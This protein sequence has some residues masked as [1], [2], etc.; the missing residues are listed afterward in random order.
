MRANSN[1]KWNYAKISSEGMITITYILD[2]WYLQLSQ[3]SVILKKGISP[4]IFCEHVQNDKSK[5]LYLYAGLIGKQILLGLVEKS[6][7]F[8]QKYLEVK[9]NAWSFAFC[10]R[11]RQNKVNIWYIHFEYVNSLSY[12]NVSFHLNKLLFKICIRKLT[13]C[14]VSSG[15]TQALWL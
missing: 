15:V 1:E 3:C 7:N 13:V 8:I 5:C 6:N 10:M 9:P 4:G 12:L 11:F 2:I 14:H